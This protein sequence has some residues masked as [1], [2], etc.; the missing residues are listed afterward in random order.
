MGAGD[1]VGD[2]VGAGTTVV[3]SLPEPLLFAG[4]DSTQAWPGLSTDETLTVN[5]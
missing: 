2:S 5:V 4:L 1:G 3:R